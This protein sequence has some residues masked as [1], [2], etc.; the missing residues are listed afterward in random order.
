MRAPSHGS[1]DQEIARLRERLESAEEMRRAIIADQ[2]DG[3]VV[4][5]DAQR[6]VLLEGTSLPPRALMEYVPQSIVAVSRAGE[7]LYANRRFGA[8]VGHPLALLFSRSMTDLVAPNDHSA[9]LDFVEASVPDSVLELTL[10]GEGGRAIPTRATAVAVGN[11]YAS[12]LI[13]EDG[14]SARQDDAESAL[15]AIR[16]GQI[17]GVVVGGEHVMLLAEAQQPYR[18]LVDRMQQGAVTVSPHGEVLYANERFASMVGVPR[19][20][21]LGKLLATVLGTTALDALIAAGSRAAALEFRLVRPDGLQLPVSVTAEPADGVDAL[22]LIVEDLTERERHR[23]I[24]ERARRNDQFL[25]VL[26][27]ELRNPLGSIRNA[28]AILERSGGHTKEAERTARG[29]IARQSETLA[30]LVDDLLDVHRLNE[31]KIVL[32]RQTIEV[33]A[34]INDAVGAVR[35]STDAKAQTIEVQLPPTPLHMEADR[36]RVAQ[37]LGNLLLNASKFTGNGG[38]IAVAAQR[39][40]R[41]GVPSVRISVSDNGIGIPHDLLDRIFEPYVQATADGSPFPDGLGLGLSVSKR[42]IELHDGTIRAHSDGPGH[43]STFAIE[44]RLCDPPAPEAADGCGEEARRSHARIL[45][46][47]DNR[48]SAATLSSLLEMMGY[49]TRIAH[50]AETAMAL[51]EEIRPDVAILDLRMPRVDGYAVAR[52]IRDRPWG[53]RLLLYALTGLGE[54]A[55]RKRTRDAGF[56]AHFVKP[57]LVEELIRDI[58]DRLS[59]R[60]DDWRHPQADAPMA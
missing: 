20:V 59:R 7:I 10:V 45:I 41:D 58:E 3:F 32:Q 4:G 48:D 34:A 60:R 53:R 35:Q 9:F 12:L 36:V 1:L 19:E 21:L 51:A 55:D 47:D 29:V 24:R 17:D 50:D 56:D 44:L 31:G 5:G 46:V 14:A 15:Q 40:E 22:T 28:V 16:E 26:A 39:T 27:H 6:V 2:L 52:M 42:L 43:G 37:V 33:G 30:R 25:A 13:D 23:A 8:L 54:P 11:G 38:R 49:E 18:A 57:V